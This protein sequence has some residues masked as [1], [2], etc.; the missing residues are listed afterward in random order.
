MNNSS[1]IAA[2]GQWQIEVANMLFNAVI[3]GTHATVIKVEA[4]FQLYPSS[5]CLLN[6]CTGGYYEESHEHRSVTEVADSSSFY[7]FYIT[8]ERVLQTSTG[9]S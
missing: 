9:R 6:C 5:L 1:S 4:F 7:L 3:R 2:S 8:A